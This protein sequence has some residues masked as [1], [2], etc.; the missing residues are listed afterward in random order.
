[1]IMAAS[2]E[3]AV[4][5]DA[6]QGDVVMQGSGSEEDTEDDD[7]PSLIIPI[8]SGSNKDQFIEIFPE[9]MAD[10]PSSTLLQVLKDEDAPL[11][12]WSDAALMYIQQSQSRE[13][14]AL[15]QAACDRPGGSREERVRIMA[16]AGIAH[17]TQAHATASSSAAKRAPGAADPHEDLRAMAD[18]KFTNATKVDTLFPMTWVGRA[19]LNLDMGRMEQANFF[20]DTTLNECGDVLPALL[21][22]AGVMFAQKQYEAAQ[23]M[24]AKAIRL[25]PKTS[26]AATRVGFGLACYRLGQVSILFGIL[27]LFFASRF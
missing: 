16:S 8:T 15:L 18:N 25:Y 1:V 5:A 20:F 2:T 13:A 3:D 23:E 22:K 11:T 4:M 24:Y 17:L 7:S 26:G 6:Q 27:L 21:G 9:E 19:M 14:S 12:V 10:T